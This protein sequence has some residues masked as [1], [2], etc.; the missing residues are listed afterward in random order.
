MTRRLAQ[1]L[2]VA[3]VVLF[4]TCAVA[5]LF[6]Y[7]FGGRLEITDVFMSGTTTV[8]VGFLALLVLRC[9]ILTTISLFEHIRHTAERTTPVEYPSFSVIIPAY[10]EGPVIEASIEGAMS[11]NYPNFEVIVVDDGSTDDTYEKAAALSARYGTRRLRVFSKANS[12]KG[13]AL[14]AG[15]RY[16]RGELVLCTDADCRLDKNVLRKAVSHFADPSVSAVAG[17]VKVANRLNVLTRLQALEYIQ[18]LN[19]VRMAQGALRKVTVIP[20]PVGIFRKSVLEAVGGYATNTFAEDCDITLQIMLHGGQIKYDMDVIAWT[21]APESP[22][23]LIKQR[24]RWSRGIL[25]AI[26]KH[27]QWLSR[28]F[29]GFMTWLSLWLF[30]FESLAMPM[31]NLAGLAFFLFTTLSGGGMSSLVVLWWAQLTVVDAVIAAYCLASEGEDLRLLFQVVVYRVFFVPFVDV[32]RALAWVDELF[33]VPM[34]WMRAE[35]VG[36]I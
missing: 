15:I 20:G 3:L 16:A 27:K 31:M 2:F 34:S 10:N 17:N 26:L 5:S 19:L 30:V 32:V 14:N 4:A 1:I 29:P 24:Y 22:F 36:R 23:T 12:G 9:V 11:L 25:Q 13:S 33:S 8:L 35:R 6:L 21:E 7:F 28:P 18:G